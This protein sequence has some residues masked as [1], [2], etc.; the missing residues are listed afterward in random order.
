MKKYDIFLFDA[1]NTLYDFD[2]AE[3]H[4]FEISFRNYGFHYTDAIREKYR[5]INRQ[6]WDKLEKGEIS[7][8]DLQT[9]RFVRLFDY[10][11]VECDAKQ[12]NDKY[13]YELGKGAFLIDGAREICEHIVSRGKKIYIVTNGILATQTS[14][15]QHSSIKDHISDFFVSEFVG[16]QKP[17]PAYFEYVLSR[18]GQIA[19]CKI[20]I[21]GDSL[22]SDIQGGIN[23]GIDTCWFNAK[24]A[25]NHTGIAPTYEIRSLNEVSQFV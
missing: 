12:F 21:V 13:L 22:A 17:H 8:D 18:I 19:K 14:R 3:A 16:H 15:I 10:V 7:K 9:S 2:K 20:L 4:A 23:I 5:E 1:D 24:N 25:D 11:S 6:E